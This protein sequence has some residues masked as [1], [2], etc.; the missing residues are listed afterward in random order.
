[1]MIRRRRRI[2]L[3]TGYVFANPRNGIT[4]HTKRG[5]EIFPNNWSIFYELG[6]TVA[7]CTGRGQL[8][9]RHPLCPTWPCVAVLDAH[10]VQKRLPPWSVFPG[11][12]DTLRAKSASRVYWRPNRRR[13]G[14]MARVGARASNSSPWPIHIFPLASIEVNTTTARPGLS[15]HER[16]RGST[17][18]LAPFR[19]KQSR[20]IPRNEKSESIPCSS[21]QSGWDLPPLQYPWVSGLDPGRG[22]TKRPVVLVLEWASRV[23]PLHAVSH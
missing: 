3:T 12:H 11:F 22:E 2:L 21:S 1:M 6:R 8:I 23:S 9:T 16:M 7:V 18:P 19:Q 14:P 5:M 10:L 17:G 4:G 20:Q 13:P 15:P